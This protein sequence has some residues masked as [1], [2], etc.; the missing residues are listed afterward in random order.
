LSQSLSLSEISESEETQTT[1]GN[2]TDT[3]EVGPL[4]QGRVYDVVGGVV[5]FREKL[6]IRR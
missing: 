1:I 5:C 4:P 6:A 2:D 3:D